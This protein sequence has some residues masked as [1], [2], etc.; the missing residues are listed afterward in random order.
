[1]P[2]TNTEYNAVLI[3]PPE[4]NVTFQISTGET[5]AFA[6][7][8]DTKST[9]KLVKCDLCG[10]FMPLSGVKNS[11]AAL[12]NHRGRKTCQQFAEKNERALASQGSS[13]PFT[14]VNSFSG[15]GISTFSGQFTNIVSLNNTDSS[16]LF[17]IRVSGSVRHCYPHC[18]FI[19]DKSY[20]L[21]LAFWSLTG[22]RRIYNASS[23]FS[24]IL[25]ANSCIR[26][27]I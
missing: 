18:N 26:N 23:I 10:K 7:Y 15:L 2:R 14:F 9:A 21:Q 4:P 5:M 6:I 16:I 24:P 20:P 13:T 11:T 25:P 27:C 8:R 17:R 1:M 19:L 3:Y 22:A 12:K